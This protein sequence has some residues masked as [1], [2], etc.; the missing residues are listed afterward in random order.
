MTLGGCR[1]SRVQIQGMT[2]LGRPA[3]VPAGFVQSQ[4]SHAH[5]SDPFP[6]LHRGGTASS[7]HRAELDTVALLQCRRAMTGKERVPAEA[8]LLDSAMCSR[9]NSKQLSPELRRIRTLSSAH[10][11]QKLCPLRNAILPC[12]KKG[13]CRH[14]ARD[15]QDI[16]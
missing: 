3:S 2:H 1:R 8:H 16:R 12:R 5:G 6:K 4:F 11:P 13:T 10:V 9:L 7:A 15:R 14:C